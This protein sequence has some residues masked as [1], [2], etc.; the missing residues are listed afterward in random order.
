MLGPM[1]EER[2]M[3]LRKEPFEEEGLAFD[4]VLKSAF[5][6][7]EICSWEKEAFPIAE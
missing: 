6:F 1:V 3:L 2:V 7:S 4:K 5:A